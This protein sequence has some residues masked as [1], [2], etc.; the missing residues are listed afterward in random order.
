MVDAAYH[1][2][3]LTAITAARILGNEIETE[4]TSTIIERINTE[5]PQYTRFVRLLDALAALA[6]SDPDGQVVAI[7]LQELPDDKITLTVAQNDAVP[8][9]LITHLKALVTRLTEYSKLDVTNEQGREAKKLAIMK[10]AYIHSDL[11]I[12][13]R[14]TKRKWLGQ[15]EK[16]LDNRAEDLGD[17]GPL[18]LEL[19]SSLMR[20]KETFDYIHNW[21]AIK[22]NKPAK[23][24]EM[25]PATQVTDEDWG[26]LI[27]EM[28]GSMPDIQCLLADKDSCDLLAEKLRGT[29]ALL[30]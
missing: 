17:A 28:D 13:R 22:T 26:K 27:L 7:S 9:K 30:D 1:P 4:R 20:I 3:V 21:K 2:N 18:C 14:F 19:V 5:T 16:V 12:S 11:K 15:L 23:Y 6:V 24:D 29:T 25:T 8:P 10:L